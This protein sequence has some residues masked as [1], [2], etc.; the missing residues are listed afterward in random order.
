MDASSLP[1]QAERVAP[2]QVASRYRAHKFGGSSL[3]DADR[4]RHVAELLRDAQTPRAVGVSAMQEIGR[5]H[6]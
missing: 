3:A 1:T 4:Y 5:A 6:V 2:E